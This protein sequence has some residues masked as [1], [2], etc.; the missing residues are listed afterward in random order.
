M[1]NQVPWATQLR[2]SQ[3]PGGCQN[4]TLTAEAEDYPY[5]KESTQLLKPLSRETLQ[6]ILLRSDNDGLGLIYRKN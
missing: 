3:G 6:G 2:T 1:R 4:Q 5:L